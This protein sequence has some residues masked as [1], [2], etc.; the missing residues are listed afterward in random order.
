MD[1]VTILIMLGLFA[2]VVLPAVVFGSRCPKCRRF[3]SVKRTGETRGGGS[4]F[5]TK[6]EQWRCRRCE[7]LFWKLGDSGGET[8]AD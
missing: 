4:F 8:S 2:L 7:H 1:P 5:E 6:E 3:A